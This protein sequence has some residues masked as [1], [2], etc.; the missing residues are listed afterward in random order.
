MLP[1]QPCSRSGACHTVNPAVHGDAVC[2]HN[3][4]RVSVRLGNDHTSTTPERR[5][6]D[7]A[8]PL[9]TPWDHIPLPGRID[10]LAWYGVREQGCR[11]SPALDH[12][13]VSAVSPQLTETTRL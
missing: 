9:R 4:C 2:A 5:C 3:D 6:A 11:S 13:R 12:V 7:P 1:Q 10:R 8:F